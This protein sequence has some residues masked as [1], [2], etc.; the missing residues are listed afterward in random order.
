MRGPTPINVTG[1]YHNHFQGLS[2]NFSPQDKAQS[3]KTQ[4]N[5]YMTGTAPYDQGHK[6][7]IPPKP[8]EPFNPDVPDSQDP[9]VKKLP[10]NPN[11]CPCKKINNFIAAL[12]LT[13]AFAKAELSLQDF[14][15]RLDDNMMKVLGISRKDACNKIMAP[16]L[17]VS[18]SVDGRDHVIWIRRSNNIFLVDVASR[19]ITSGT[20]VIN[21][22]E[23]V[24]DEVEDLFGYIKSHEILHLPPLGPNE[25]FS[26]NY[27]VYLVGD[28]ADFA[29]GKL[30]VRDYFE[31]RV[32]DE[33]YSKIWRMA[34]RK[35]DK[36]KVLERK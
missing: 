15:S 13:A 6:K 21:S 5:S 4:K 2:G 29:V 36:W 22:R 10:N 32:V 20:V 8:N 30:I 26:E 3:F 1:I 33:V 35:S 18:Y 31:S 19:E 23:L 28:F 14:E 12:L 17:V 25:D 24:R 27:F 16:Y 7:H 11:E 9:N 34:H